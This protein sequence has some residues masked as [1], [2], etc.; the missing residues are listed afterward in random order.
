LM[1]KNR[2]VTGMYDLSTGLRLPAYD[3]DG[4]L[5]PDNSIQLPV[6]R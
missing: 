2:L 4:T 3:K 5:L 1:G 6:E